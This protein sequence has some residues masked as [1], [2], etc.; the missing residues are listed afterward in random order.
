MES[1]VEHGVG[2]KSARVV[3][4][5]HVAITSKRVAVTTVDCAPRNIIAFQLVGIER[6]DV[7]SVILVKVGEVIVEENRL[8]HIF[9]DGKSQ[10][11]DVGVDFYSCVDGS[12]DIGLVSPPG[13]DGGIRTFEGRMNVVAG[14]C[15]VI[16][17]GR[18]GALVEQ[19]EY[20]NRSS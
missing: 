3:G 10:V 16:I 13:V 19:S 20:S 18:A 1:I 5:F 6:L 14:H 12:A 15:L 2:N 7:S 17:V 11:A 9:G 8:T 4:F